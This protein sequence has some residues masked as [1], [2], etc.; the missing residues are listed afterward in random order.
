[1]IQISG[2]TRGNWE[3]YYIDELCSEVNS[4]GFSHYLYY[5]GNHIKELYTALETIG[6]NTITELLD[7][8]IAEFP[9]KKLP[10]SLERIQDAID[11]LEAKGINFDAQ[12]SEYYS[13]VEKILLEKLTSYV[14]DNKNNFR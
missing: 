2:N 12:D 5:R 1:M 14:I 6:A 13:G 9:R 7:R 10:T 3:F 4:G 11:K 8:I